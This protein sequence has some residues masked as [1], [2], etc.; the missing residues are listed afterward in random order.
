MSLSHQIPVVPTGPD[1][2]A[3]EK[4]PENAAPPQ[5]T[6]PPVDQK[7][8][9]RP[10][11]IPEKFWDA[12]KGAVR[13]EDMAKAYSELEKKQSAPGDKKPDEKPADQK[14]NEQK[15]E[16]KKQEPPQELPKP[17]V[18]FSE[19]FSK[20]GKLSDESYKELADKHGLSR[21]YVDLYI[22]GV[23]A[24]QTAY[25]DAVYK[26]TGGEEGFQKLSEWANANVPKEELTAVDKAL[27]S[28][29]KAQ[30]A[31][32]VRG[33]HARYQAENGK[34]PNLLDGETTGPSGATPFQST[35]E[36]V[37]AM[38]DPRYAKDP[39]YR[40]EIDK[41]LAVSDVI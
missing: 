27:A 25:F 40:A 33:L 32:A 31:L 16:D 26:E 29:D 30:A 37:K 8:A 1:A 21:E 10:A 38:S 39:A 24:T 2:P 23:Q 4:K 5:N 17:F 11:N 20:E 7:S 35:A 34:E 6:T 19:E 41:R 28:G 22:A 3:P 36:V 15:P 14:P 18:K 13:T 9:E 12:E